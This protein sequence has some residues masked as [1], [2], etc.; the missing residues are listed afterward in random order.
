MPLCGQDINRRY[1]NGHDQN[2]DDRQR[3]KSNCQYV[4]CRCYISRGICSTRRSRVPGIAC[5]ISINRAYAISA[6]CD[7]SQ[8]KGA[9]G[10]IVI[11]CRGIACITHWTCVTSI[12]FTWCTRGARIGTVAM[13]GTIE[14]GDT[15]GTCGINVTI[16][17]TFAA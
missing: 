3:N 9:R 11:I 2:H 15:K 10:V 8:A 17:R 6:A 1:S 7:G 14:R 12:A 5:T 4:G 16:G 13:S